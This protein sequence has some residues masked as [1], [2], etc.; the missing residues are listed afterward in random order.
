M[1]HDEIIALPKGA[2]LGRLAMSD[3]AGD[4]YVI[5]LPFRWM[6]GAVSGV[7][8]SQTTPPRSVASQARPAARPIL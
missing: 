1:P 7:R 8:G 5:P 2:R 4:P 6:K 3:R